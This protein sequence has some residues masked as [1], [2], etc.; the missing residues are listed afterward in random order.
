MFKLSFKNYPFDQ[1]FNYREIKKPI[2][3]NLQLTIPSFFL[4]AYFYKLIVNKSFYSYLLLITSIFFP[5]LSHFLINSIILQK[6][7]YISQIDTIP[8]EKTIIFFY[9]GLI[10]FFIF[11]IFSIVIKIRSIVGSFS[12]FISIIYSSLLSMRYVIIYIST[13]YNRRAIE[14]DSLFF[15]IIFVIFY[16]YFGL[17]LI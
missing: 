1:L 7:K 8:I 16:S 4:L 14:K 3:L 15:F 11:S 17:L 13:D 5:L 9:T 10:P 12:L 6:K 2:L